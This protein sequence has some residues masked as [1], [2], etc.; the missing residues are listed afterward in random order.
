MLDYLKENWE[1]WC[2]NRLVIYWDMV[3]SRSVMHFKGTSVAQTEL[4]KSEIKNIQWSPVSNCKIF[5]SGNI[6]TPL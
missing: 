6:V 1:S 4:K 2:C 5:L 3:K